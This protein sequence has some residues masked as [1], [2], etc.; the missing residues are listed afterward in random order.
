MAAAAALVE[1]MLAERY[2]E[3]LMGWLARKPE[4]PAS[5]QEAAQFGDSL[6][7]LTAAELGELGGQIAELVAQ[8]EERIAA[9]GE[10]RP[11]RAPSAAISGVSHV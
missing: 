11:T 5:W 7:R 10:R 9:Q 1:S 6:L 8:F 3:E 4:E 2:F